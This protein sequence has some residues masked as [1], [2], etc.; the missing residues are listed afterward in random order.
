[1]N[2]ISFKLKKKIGKEI[3]ILF[4]KYRNTPFFIPGI[5]LQKKLSLF[6][7]LS[8]ILLFFF[9]FKKRV[10]PIFKYTGTKPGELTFDGIL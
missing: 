1:M 7:L 10:S 6:E 9:F 4:L 3:K 5:N 2:K 8:R